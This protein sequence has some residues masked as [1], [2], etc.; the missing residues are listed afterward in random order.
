MNRNLGP[1]EFIGKDG[2]L[3]RY[4][5]GG[6]GMPVR[7]M[8]KPKQIV[9]DSYEVKANVA[10]PWCASHNLDKLSFFRNNVRHFQLSKQTFLTNN[11]YFFVCFA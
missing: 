8:N 11:F 7:V 10:V 2:L 5:D 1:Q 4:P 9:R 6:G 3:Y